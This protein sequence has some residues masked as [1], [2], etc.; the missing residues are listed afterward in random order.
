[1]VVNSIVS[2]ALFVFVVCLVVWCNCSGG[3]LMYCVCLNGL[4]GWRLVC[5]VADIAGWNYVVFVIA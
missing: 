5:L 2:V 1:M 3:C 4:C